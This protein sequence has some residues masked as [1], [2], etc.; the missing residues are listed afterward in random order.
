MAV[1]RPLAAASAAA[2]TSAESVDGERRREGRSMC[3]VAALRGGPKA[4]VCN[5]SGRNVERR[6]SGSPA[7]LPR[8]LRR[9]GMVEA[10]DGEDHHSSKT[11]SMAD[12]KH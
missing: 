7:R 11:G 3:E 5:S 4:V 10:D 12:S 2:P 8:L 1:V 6:I 9:N